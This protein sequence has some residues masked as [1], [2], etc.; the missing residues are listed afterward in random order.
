MVEQLSQAILSQLLAEFADRHLSA[1]DLN[2]GYIGM[3]IVDL[4][5]SCCDEP[6]APA[7]DFD[8]AL[9][10]LEE[11][12]LIQ[13]G[14]LVPYNNPPNSSVMV[15]GIFSNREYAYLT[16]KGYKAARKTRVTPVLKDRVRMSFQNTFHGPVGN[17]AQNSDH[18]NQ[19]AN[20]RV[21]LGDLVKLVTDLATHLDELNLDARQKQR[22]EAQIAALNA[23][24]RGEADPEIV[25]QAGRTLRNITE[26]AIGSLIATAT[27]PGVWHWIHHMLS[28]F[29]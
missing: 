27:Q 18:V 8:L 14:P 7:V 29:Q 16:E 26:G 12:D 24:L 10:E 2:D 3:N 21:P 22:A 11:G 17:I 13:T 9:K 6:S 1:N 23:E 19:T 15:I 28:K 5:Q 20:I 4:R 25:N